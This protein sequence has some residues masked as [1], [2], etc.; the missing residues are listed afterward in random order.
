MPNALLNRVSFTCVGL[1]VAAATASSIVD[2][3]G[4]S[5]GVY[6][7]TTG[8]LAIALVVSAVVN[9]PDNR[10]WPALLLIAASSIAGQILD[11]R[12]DNPSTN[13]AIPEALF[14]VV[15]LVLAAG[16]TFIVSSRLGSDPLSVVVD[17][18]IVGLGAWFLIWV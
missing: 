1:G 18:I 9:K 6:L 3:D 11:A 4:V 16:L 15:Q 17:G 14:L 13:Q 8:L 5:S 2:R 12:F 10:I 7:V